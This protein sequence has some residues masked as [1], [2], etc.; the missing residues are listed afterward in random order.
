MDLAGGYYDAGDNVKFGFPMAFSAT[1]LSWGIL[2]FGNYM[3]PQLQ[4]AREAV[5]WATDYLLKATAESEKI[6]VQVGDPY[7]DHACWERPEDMDTSRSVYTI[8]KDRPG[9][10]VAAET[11]AALAAA[12][13][14]F[15]SVDPSYSSALLQRSI[16]VRVFFCLSF[17][18]SV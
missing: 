16:T 14:V 5:R 18:S 6:H 8:D 7:G 12:S 13:L 9:T 11:A 17:I 15:K 2:E 1:V 4:Y 10:E 3:G